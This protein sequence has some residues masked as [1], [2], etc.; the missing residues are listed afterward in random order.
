M[1]AASGQRDLLFALLALQNGIVSRDALLDALAEWLLESKRPLGQILIDRK[2]LSA[3]NFQFLNQL[4]DGCAVSEVNVPAPGGAEPE[5]SA[6]MAAL[7][8]T[9]QGDVPLAAA[10][11]AA[12]NGVHQLSG[13]R[14]EV[15][16]PYARGGLGQVSVAMDLELNREVAVK[17]LLDHAAGSSEARARFL[18]EAEV[19]SQLEHP[20]VV[21]V[22]GLGIGAKGR[23]YYAMRLI[24]GTTL[25]QAI[26]LLNS[27]DNRENAE[28][29]RQYR[30]LLRRFIA[31]CETM[32]FAHS[33]GV[34]HRD[35]KPLNIMLGD[36]GETLIVDWGLAKTVGSGQWAVSSEE[37]KSNEMDTP[38]EPR[39]A[40][41]GTLS[42]AQLTQ[43]GQILGTPSYMSPEQ[44]AGQWEQ[45]GPASD[46]FS[47]GAILY[48]ILT[49]RPP[50]VGDRAAM[51]EQSRAGT[52]I[53]ARQIN[54][55]APLALDAVC[56]KAMAF[57]PARRYSSAKDLAAELDRWLGDE[58]V[59][60]W[61]EPILVRLGRWARRRRGWVAAASALLLTSVVG[62]AIGLFAVDRERRQT[63]KQREM[64]QAAIDDMLTPE[65]LDSL[66]MQKE[67]Q[68][69]QRKFLEGALKY[70][71]EL[72]AAASSDGE[73]RGRQARVHSVIGQIYARVNDPVKA[74][75]AFRGATP[76]YEQLIAEFP[77]NSNH[78]LNYA[79]SQFGLGQLL[80]AQKRFE[81]GLGIY[82]DALPHFEQLAEYNPNDATV[83]N[84]LAGAYLTIGN[85][86]KFVNR[87]GDAEP[88]YR[89]CITVRERLVADHPGNDE[90]RRDLSRPH[91]NLALMFN[92]LGRCE[93]AEKELRDVVVIR[94]GLVIRRPDNM[95]FKNDLAKGLINL[96][97]QLLTSDRKVE[98]ESQ[99]RRALALQEQ[100]VSHYPGVPEFQEQLGKWHNELGSVLGDL[101]RRTDA[102]A[103]HRRAVAIFEKLV[104]TFPAD[105]RFPGE[106]SRS[107]CHIG[108]LAIGVDPEAAL[109]WFNRGVDSVIS[110]YQK[111][112]KIESNREALHA[113]RECRADAFTRLKRYDEA[114]AERDAAKEKS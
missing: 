84:H 21:P 113:A 48:A 34:I 10:K 16:R 104:A 74:E 105:L 6:V 26:D 67:L 11:D 109:T 49:G 94:E 97:I 82:R 111:N 96:G 57:D 85:T 114:R 78:R 103:A 46:I 51:M 79:L 63:L 52:W 31:V 69:S 44:A 76:I 47:L 58:P 25:Q 32:A 70:Y 100:V 5:A 23:P 54:A 87:F 73:T 83:L 59:T 14:Y 8:P 24:K 77:D 4:V 80:V 64:T 42:N 18:R 65:V 1:V 33:R 17:E 36:Y 66:V 61:R 62:L 99:Y 20:G 102:E 98:A 30:E 95:E 88:Y 92:S 15:R 19:T 7:L 55:N 93:E 38:S 71:R 107:Y 101:D 75:A 68:P 108:K 13:D 37:K 91:N 106:L 53:P 2:S 112:P 35:L 45:L 41:D 29:R 39:R 27:K 50:F 56:R 40:A 89:K 12:S 22:Y 28:R 43:A 3:A 72:A 86:M 110:A 9:G 60:A 90:F 81:E